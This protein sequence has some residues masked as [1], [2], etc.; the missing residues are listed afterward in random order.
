[1]SSAP[2]SCAIIPHGRSLGLLPARHDGPRFPRDPQGTTLQMPSGE[3]VR[4]SLYSRSCRISELV[5]RH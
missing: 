1:M 5:V 4:R 2:R 3:V